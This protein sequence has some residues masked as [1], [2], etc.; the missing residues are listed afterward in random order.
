MC[1]AVPKAGTLREVAD[2]P[3][4]ARQRQRGGT[5]TLA[6]R[7][8]LSLAIGIAFAWTGAPAQAQQKARPSPPWPEAI[9]DNSFLIEE[10]YNQDPQVVQHITTFSYLR[11]SLRG[12][13]PERDVSF[14]QEWPIGG[15]AHQL[16]Y[17]IPYSWASGGGG[18]GDILVN[19][20]YQLLGHD[21]WAALAP[22]VS[23][24]VASGAGEG[25]LPGVQVCLP[26]SKRLDAW[27]VVH[28]NAAA[29]LFPSRGGHQYQLGA[30][31]IGLVTT[32]LNLMLEV[33]SSLTIERA[34]GIPDSRSTE[35]IL[36]PGVRYAIDL[37]SLQI[38]PGVA[39][40]V[41]W[42]GGRRQAGILAYLSFEHPF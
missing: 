20:R 3:S 27:L 35:T 9:E 23:L 42:Q 18:L 41:H 12:S 10:A 29:T 22:R 13:A 2:G 37:G 1:E 24:I 26:A 38:V 25:S 14:T 31:V 36:S 28:G 30:S 33:L 15:R 32:R 34:Q 5:V 4:V 21:A 40:P 16:S 11:G 19:Y 6:A 39:V 8:R 17:T 7:W